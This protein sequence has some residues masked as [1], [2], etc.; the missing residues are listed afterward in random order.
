[1]V[2]GLGVELCADDAVLLGAGRHDHR[3]GRGDDEQAREHGDDDAR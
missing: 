2:V 3:R 1:M